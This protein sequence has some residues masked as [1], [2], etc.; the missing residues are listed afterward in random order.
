MGIRASCCI[1][2]RDADKAPVGGEAHLDED[3][4]AA[5]DPATY[6]EAPLGSGDIYR[7]VSTM[8]TLPVSPLTSRKLST[9]YNKCQQSSRPNYL[10]CSENIGGPRSADDL[11]SYLLSSDSRSRRRAIE[12]R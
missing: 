6:D 12:R 5:D 10:R 2:I 3:D 11:T 9:Q 8:S 1:N 7:S 4:D